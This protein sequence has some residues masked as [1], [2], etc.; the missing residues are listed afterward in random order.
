MKNNTNKITWISENGKD[1]YPNRYTEKKLPSGIYT[2]KYSQDFGEYLSR[3]EWKNDF[4]INYLDNEFDTIKDD[5]DIFWSIE[6]KYKTNGLEFNR[7]IMLHGHPGCGKKYL[8]RRVA[9]YFVEN[10][11]GIVI[12]SDEPSDLKVIL[13]NIKLNSNKPPKIMVVIE[14]AG[15]L[16]EKN[17]ISSMTGVFKDK[18]NEDGVYYLLTTNFEE[19]FG[20]YISDKPGYIE[21]SFLIDYPDKKEIESYVK[22]LLVFMEVKADVKQISKDVEGLSIGHIRNLIESH[23]IFGY[24]Y[25]ETLMDIKDKQKNIIKQFYSSSESY[26]I[27]FGG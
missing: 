6:K 20:D 13:E 17:G 12:Y 15:I 19:K 27:G 16:L 10:Y 22:Q 3:F 9:D 26:D 2:S 1:Y 7:A 11:N 21:K 5:L 8:C 25:E 4:P 18:E 24:E 14:D 23:F